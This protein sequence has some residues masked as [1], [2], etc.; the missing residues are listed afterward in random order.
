MNVNIGK[1]HELR[2]QRRRLECTSRL[3]ERSTEC[4][5]W[6]TAGEHASAHSHS[7]AWVVGVYVA[8]LVTTLFIALSSLRISLF[9]LHLAAPLVHA[10]SNV[11]RQLM[12]PS[13]HVAHPHPI[14]MCQ[15]SVVDFVSR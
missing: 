1:V 8:R 5:A 9:C 7:R 13:A 6:F 15:H 11:C 2:T 3:D 14:D 12:W 10:S 4:E